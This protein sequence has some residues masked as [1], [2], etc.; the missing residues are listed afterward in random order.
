MRTGTAT[1]VLF[2]NRPGFTLK[3]IAHELLLSLKGNVTVDWSR[4]ESARARMRVLVKRILRK[5]GIHLI[6]R[7]LWCKRCSG[8]RKHCQQ[9][10]RSE[11]REAMPV[12]TPPAP[13][14]CPG[15]GCAFAIAELNGR[16][17]L[18]RDRVR[19]FGSE[20]VGLRPSLEQRALPQCSVFRLLQHER[21]LR[22]RELRRLH[23]ILLVPEPGI[24][25]GKF[26]LK[27]A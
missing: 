1:P 24:I 21:D 27:L 12:E 14:T 4:R 8:K 20:L 13:S 10:G 6:S 19:R 25:N 23:G 2:L 3:L 16:A 17:A 9:L 11:R 22:F 5:H 15:L 26:Q 7:T 18:A